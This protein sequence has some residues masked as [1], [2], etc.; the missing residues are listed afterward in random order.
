MYTTG[1][2]DFEKKHMYQELYEEYISQIYNPSR[3]LINTKTTAVELVLLILSSVSG[4]TVFVLYNIRFPVMWLKVIDI[5]LMISAVVLFALVEHK[6]EKSKR[7]HSHDDFLKMRD[8]LN[9][10]GVDYANRSVVD[11]IINDYKTEQKRKTHVDNTV[12]IGLLSAMIGS[13]VGVFFTKLGVAEWASFIDAFIN[14]LM[15]MIWI[16][17]VYSIIKRFVIHIKAEYFSE[18]DVFCLMLSEANIF[19]HMT[20][21]QAKQFKKAKNKEN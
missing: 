16:Y 14:I 3:S 8:L 20:E 18:I 13:L 21:K 15:L 9:K 17:I 5:V 11:C 19:C 7:M 4:I 12:V 2:K 6:H 10:Y 1:K